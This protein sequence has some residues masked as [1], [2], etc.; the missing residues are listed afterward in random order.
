MRPEPTPD[1]SNPKSKIQ[2]RKSEGRAAL[3]EE[4]CRIIATLRGPDG[5]PWD[6]EQTHASLKKYLLEESYETLEAIEQEK[7]ALL[8]EEL[9]DVLLQIA[10]HSQ[11]AEEAGEFSISEVIGGISEKMV[12][13]HPHVFGETTVSGAAEVVRNW[14]AIKAEEK[15]NRPADAPAASALDGIPREAPAL[16]K[17]ME[18]SKRA[19]RV[20]FEWERLED[21]WSKVH[22]ELDELK[23]AA[24]RK[25]TEEIGSELG[26]LLFTLVNVAR[27]LKVDP[28]ESLRRMVDRFSERFRYMEARIA[29]QGRRMEDLPLS[30]LDRIWEEAK[31]ALKPSN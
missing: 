17:A 13:R 9:G 14:E 2:N 1:E 5:C 8:C 26:D 4:F 16:M 25:D 11:I 15:A 10:L 30:E 6:R 31:A 21:V 22:E 3:F 23:D 28:E 18:T 27:W 20:G 7:P 19:V 24:E 12:R 29:G